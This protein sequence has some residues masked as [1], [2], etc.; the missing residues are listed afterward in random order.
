M[1]KCSRR[2]AAAAR[3]RPP[4]GSARP[5]TTRSCRTGTL[6]GVDQV[7]RLPPVEIVLRH[8]GLGEL[9]PAL[10]LARGDGAEERVAP[11]LLVAA[12]VVDLV[13]LVPAPELGPD[14]VPQEL[15]ELDP[16]DR[17]HAA[18]SPEIEIEVLAE[19]SRLE[20]LRVR[21]EEDET[22]RHGLLDEVLDLDVG[23]GRQ[24]LI[25]RGRL[26]AGQD[27]ASRPRVVALLHRIRQAP[28]HVAPGDDLADVRLHATNRPRAGDLVRLYQEAAIDPNLA[29]IVE[30]LEELLAGVRE[31]QRARLGGNGHG[32]TP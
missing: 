26:H 9:L 2:P 30:A 19:V 20:V 14:R 13:E 25:R 21:V 15:H 16:P 23:L 8:A 24:H 29:T 1:R 3:P 28:D 22:A 6:S 12:G 5:R 11:D 17:V 32:R 10:V 7:L 27:A 18:R 31:R 4:P